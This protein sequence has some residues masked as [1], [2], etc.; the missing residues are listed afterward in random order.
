MASDGE[1]IGGR[2]SFQGDQSA[3]VYTSFRGSL[4]GD[5]EVEGTN[6]RLFGSLSGG[7]LGKDADAVALYSEP[8]VV[9]DGALPGASFGIPLDATVAVLAER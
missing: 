4:D 9:A 6:V 3:G 5:L 8:T 7:A 2:I 1:S